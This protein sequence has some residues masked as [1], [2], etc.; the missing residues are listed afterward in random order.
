MHGKLPKSVRKFIREE[1]ARIRRA[2]HDP[3]ERERRIRALGERWTS[4]GRPAGGAGA[5][6]S[7]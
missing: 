6:E 4:F 2:V 3:A 1:K 7:A 5:Q